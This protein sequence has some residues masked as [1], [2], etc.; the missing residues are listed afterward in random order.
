MSP[1]GRNTRAKVLLEWS[2]RFKMEFLQ[3]GV[4]KQTIQR[5]R[6]SDNGSGKRFGPDELY[7]MCMHGVCRAW[8]PSVLYYYDSLL[9]EKIGKIHF[10]SVFESP[11]T[12]PHT[13]I[14]GY[15]W[16]LQNLRNSVVPVRQLSVKPS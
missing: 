11:K 3:D 15:G 14:P 13:R 5:A 6:T 4:Q 8:T 12:P 2:G 7:A 10:S 9:S 16:N 1:G